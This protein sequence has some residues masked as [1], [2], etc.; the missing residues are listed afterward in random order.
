MGPQL[1]ELIKQGS[2]R[3]ELRH[4]PLRP[5]SVWGVEAAECAGEQGYWWAM[6]DQ[7]FAN[8]ARG[9]STQITI[10]HARALGLDTKAFEQCVTKDKY[11]AFA[12]Q[13]ATEADKAGVPGTPFFLVNGKVVTNYNQV[14]DAVKKELNP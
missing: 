14:I 7:I 1:A 12:K 11:V 13:K 2:V 3:L 10:E 4:F 9:L 6:H 5:E 8:Q